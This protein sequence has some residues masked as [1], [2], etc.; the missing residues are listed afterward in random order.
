M[1]LTNVVDGNGGTNLIYYTNNSH[2]ANLISQVVDAFGRTN[3]LSYDTNGDLTNI[4]D[5]G[6]ISSSFAYDT[7]DWIT[8]MT[9][10]YGT[11]TFAITDTPATNIAPNGR[12]ILVTDPD[13][14]QQ[15]F[16]NKDSAPGVAASYANNQVP[17]TN[18]FT[19]TFDNSDLNLRNTFWWG[20]RQYAAL[21]TTNV[22]AFNTNDFLK[23][24][25]KHWLQSAAFSA[26]QTISIQRDESPD[27][28]GSIAGQMTWYDY[29]DKTNTEFEGTQ[30][31]PLFVG[32]V[33]PDGTTA[34]TR[35]DR[36]SFGSPTTSIQ[37]YT[38]GT[39]VSLRTNHFAY[40][41]ND[42]DL[43]T[44]DNAQGVQVISNAFNAFHEATNNYDALNEQTLFTYDT[45]QRLTRITFP[46]GLV[47]TN[48]YG[49]DNYLA[50]RINIGFAT[51]SFTYSNGLLN[52][53]T[54]ARGLTIM[55]TWDNLQRLTSITF[56][57][58][59]CISN[60]YTRLDRTASKDRLNNWMYFGYDALRHNIA[61]TNALTHYTLFSY[62][63]CGALESIQDALGNTTWFN[64][65]NES[66]MTNVLYPDGSS[67]TYS[68]NLIGQIT[69][70]VDGRGTSTTNWFNNQGLLFAVSNAFG[71]VSA[72]TYDILDRSTNTVDAN[73]VSVNMTYD[74]LGRMLTRSYPDTGTERFGY[75]PAGMI[76]YTNQL[77]NVTYY[78]YDAA[79]RKIAE[80]N[81]NLQ[82]MQYAYDAANHLTNLTDAKTNLTQW[83]Y[84]LYG[85]VTNKLDAMTNTILKYQYDA[86]N[87]LTNR[88]SLAKSNT[89]YA[90]DAVG[91]LTN[92]TYYH[93]NHSLT[94]CYDVLNRM[95]CMSDG[96]GTTE[97]NY[98]P[99][100]QLTSESGPWTSDTITYSYSDQLRM[101]LDLQQPNGS[102]WVQGYAY[103][104][105]NRLQ[106]TTSPVGTFGYTYN[107]GLA[108]T[109]SS[110][111]LIANIA[112]PNQAFITNIYDENARLT[113]TSLV[114]SSG[115]ALDYSGYS[116]NQG[117][118]RAGIV[119]GTTNYLSGATNSSYAN[120]RYDP[121][122]QVT[123]DLAYEARAF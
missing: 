114:N 118:Q 71:Q 57:D 99:T 122:G 89:V 28:G 9:T 101:K 39:F 63:P 45:N 42:I 116:Y 73:G 36:N 32:R 107:P 95:T 10:P 84:D 34:L 59:T 104:A 27:N 120:Y 60:E 47:T 92:V 41:T 53:C 55:N 117:N 61:V 52:T 80:T 8:N 35:N 113:G 97:F 21:S 43:V 16:L 29:T 66:R 33:L 7:N 105:A 18:P 90:Y 19:N 14:S 74:D 87:R 119:R 108:G 103:D 121:I 17:I 38:A 115:T 110:S 96:I 3:T 109:T 48:V 75:S 15:L 50:Q 76:A 86:D 11:T 85:R 112:L 98:T 67:V 78:G 123:S 111:S 6:G 22:A 70:V 82:V 65:D 64:Y 72:A 1:H 54:D 88:W 106:T 91:N 93:T 81:A 51:N 31:L 94:F 13:G 62:C 56:P 46:T 69:N 58:G 40:A 44:V 83:G 100:G 25:M 4:T 12:S 24:R 2:G 79:G 37:T 102:D 5:V 20:S 49:S 77:T 30:I 26:S 68:Y 23:A